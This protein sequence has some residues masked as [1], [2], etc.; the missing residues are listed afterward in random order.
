V[1][2]LLSDSYI[3]AA[4]IS[5]A[6]LFSV[7]YHLSHGSNWKY[8]DIFLAFTLITSNLFAVV[9]ASIGYFIVAI[10]LSLLSGY[11][12]FYA[13]KRNYILYHPYWHVVSVAITSTCTFG[14]LVS[15]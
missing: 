14:Y 11:I 1:F 13:Q 5:V 4:V 9:Q 12:Y 6:V 2:T 3:H 7:L 8:Y 10:V 15:N